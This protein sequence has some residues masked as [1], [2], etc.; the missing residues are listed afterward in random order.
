MTTHIMVRLGFQDLG[1]LVSTVAYLVIILLSFFFIGLC[2][3][4]SVYNDSTAPDLAQSFVSV[5]PVRVV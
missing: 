1:F 2:I 3:R 5:V 4:G